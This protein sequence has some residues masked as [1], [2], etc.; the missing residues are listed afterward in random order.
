[1]QLTIE[2]TRA[3][4]N[5][6]FDE[7]KAAAQLQKRY[8]RVLRKLL[9]NLR[10]DHGCRAHGDVDP[11]LTE[12]HLILRVIDPRDD[13]LHVELM[14]SDLA[15]DKVVFMGHNMNGGRGKPTTVCLRIE[16][17]SPKLLWK[18]PELN[19][20]YQSP[21]HWKGHLYGVD[22]RK[23]NVYCCDMKTGKVVW[24]TS[25][26]TT[27]GGKSPK[28][29]KAFIIAD[30]KIVMVNGHGVLVVG[31]VSSKGHKINAHATVPNQ[32]KANWVYEV[33]PVLSSGKLYYRNS[34]GHL[35]CLAMGDSE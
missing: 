9:L 14:A 30:G 1:M 22:Y 5:L 19:H 6:D 2:A 18:I 3:L 13:A 33:C 12:D 23:G 8:Q 11:Q 7:F 4:G 10:E 32:E 25:E 24:S 16:K 34:K 29:G 20:W 27:I 15:G 26:F 21:V 17:G 35:V 28:R 31:E